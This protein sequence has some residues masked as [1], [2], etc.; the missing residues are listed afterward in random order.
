MRALAFLW[1]RTLL[2]SVRGALRRPR[3]LVPALFLL[4]LLVSQLAGFW[5]RGSA[6][7]VGAAGVAPVF[8]RTEL[9]MGGPGAFVVALRGIFLLAL[10]S[11]LVGALGESGLLFA[12]SD[13]DYLFPAPLS[14]RAVLFW[15]M[16]GKYGGLLFPAA[17]L[18]LAVGNAALSDARVS[19]WAFAP[20]IIGAWLFLASVANIAQVLVLGRGTETETG[21]QARQQTRRILTMVLVA[22]VVGAAGIVVC[23][24]G[25]GGVFA[26]R[27]FL[28]RIN[29]EQITR[30]LLPDAWAADL[31]LVAFRGWTTG[32]V[33]R[34]LG[35]I[36]LAGLSF[37]LLFA[38]D[39]D[40]YEEALETT[41]RRT[42]MASA[43]R[44]GDAGAIVSALAQEGKL[45][46]GRGLPPFGTGARAL[47]WK[48]AVAATRTP[49]RAWAQLAFVALLPALIGGIF[50]KRG[51]D[52]NVL[53]WTFLF[54]LQM[55]PFFLLG[56]RDMLRRADI[57]KALPLSPT[58][59]LCAEL[60]LS[61]AQLTIV[62]WFSLSV[63]AVTGLGR[64]PL[65]VVAYLVLPTLAA[66]LLTVQTVFVLL[67]PSNNDPAQNTI[68]NL[69]SIIASTFAL[70]PAVTVGVLLFFAGV[71]PALLGVSVALVNVVCAAIVLAIATLL[72]QR[73]DPTT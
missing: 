62:G 16:L 38:R 48:D 66:L 53:F 73:F 30:T 63:M 31:F 45:G 43:L 33:L 8:T 5:V 44:S 46:K 17:Y 27:S 49:P 42:R 41:S 35:L 68:S 15:K 25:P 64:G 4:L 58:R 22:F 19:L 47:L 21:E 34:L 26:L 10:F 54:T 57:S 23:A 29:S 67:Y 69:L 11:T 72:W 2:G 51:S 65:V 55:S 28:F 14:R 60:T 37:A 52:V 1:T 6:E 59:F 56:L 39:R 36:G 71:G 18:P 24:M 9:L 70:I 13:V 32:D 40:F 7:G 20:G 50:G 61:V 12:Q 3:T